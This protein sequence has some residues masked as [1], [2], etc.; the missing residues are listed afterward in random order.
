MEKD[1]SISEN[2]LTACDIL[3]SER[4]RAFVENIED[5]VYE[6]DIHGNFLYFNDSLCR[7][8][9]Y[10]REAIQFQNFASFMDEERAKQ[11][12]DAFT[13]L[14]QTG[15]AFSDLIWKIKKKDGKISIIELSANLIT[16]KAGEKIGFRGI[17]RDI[18][19][20]FNAQEALK[21]SERRF[22]TLLDFV[23]YPLVV[24][25]LNGRVTY[26]NP[27]FTENF[28][29]TLS[30]LE[31]KTIPYVP[32]DFEQQTS[33]NIKKLFKERIIRRQETRRLTK[34][35]RALDV[36]F[37]AA[38]YSET[39]DAPSGE[40][41]ILRDIT[42]EKRIARNNEALLRVSMAV[43]KYPDLQ[44]LLDFI[45]DELKRLMG[46]EGALVILLDEEKNE[47]FFKSGAH[48]D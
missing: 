3:S 27:S 9:G 33:E 26:L 25:T 37:R 21:K 30:E 32:P 12:F 13:R 7:I 41:V 28:G 46:I 8:F 22:R 47:F 17:A 16:N 18:T 24:F 36:T 29:W 39:E 34:D 23:P 40:L 5:G 43:P 19:D 31:G 20:K 4:Y 10:P 45:G 6:L 38:V 2:D 44:E 42:K 14:Y 35:G 48:D 11:G 15:H 1:N